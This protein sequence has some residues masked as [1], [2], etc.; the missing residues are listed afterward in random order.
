MPFTPFHL[1]P[2]LLLGVLLYRHLDLG[3][4]LA[5]SIAVDLRTVLVFS[6]CWTALCMELCTPSP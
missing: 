6:G 2:G 1:G 4:V 5:A 3:T